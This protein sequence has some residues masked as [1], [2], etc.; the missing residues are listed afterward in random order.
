MD[1]V[2]ERLTVWLSPILPFTCEE[3]WTTRFPNAGSNC[4]RV[5]PQT[6][7]AWRN[8][9]KGGTRWHHLGLQTTLDSVTSVLEV[10]RRE[11]RIGSALEAAKSTCTSRNKTCSCSR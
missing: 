10:E 11:K 7:E 1:A 4:L 5:M 3:A 8:D 9:G 6:P 2:F